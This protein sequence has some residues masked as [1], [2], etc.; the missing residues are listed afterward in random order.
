MVNVSFQI[1]DDSEHNRKEKCFDLLA[2]IQEA[3][4][5]KIAKLNQT[6]NGDDQFVQIC[7]EL[8]EYLDSHDE[9]I[10]DCYEGQF[11]YIYEYIKSFF[12][13]ELA[14]SINYINCI[15]KLTSEK[16]EEIKKDLEEEEEA[17]KT[18]EAGRQVLTDPVKES[19]TKPECDNSPCDTEHSGN[20]AMDDGNQ[21]NLGKDGEAS[22]PHIQGSPELSESLDN[23][24]SL[25]P[26]PPASEVDGVS[27]VSRQETTNNTVHAAGNHGVVETHSSSSVPLHGKINDGSDT[28]GD[29]HV[30][31]LAEGS[32]LHGYSPESKPTVLHAP[33]GGE[34]SSGPPSS[35]GASS[36]SGHSLSSGISAPVGKHPHGHLSLSEPSLTVGH[37]PYAEQQQSSLLESRALEQKSDQELKSSKEQYQE[38]IN[39]HGNSANNNSFNNNHSTLRETTLNGE[40]YFNAD[41]ELAKMPLDVE[42][43]D[44]STS[45]Q[46]QE[47]TSFKTYLTIILAS[48]GVMLLS[49]LLIKFTSVGG[50]FRRKK[51]EKRQKMREELD[52]IMYTPS[53]LEEDNIY[54]SY[55]QPEYSSYYAEYD[56]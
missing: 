8:G 4:D 14:K 39:Y 42:D 55:S 47:I 45:V 7:R 51:N 25:N 19:P 5:K 46:E 41:T 38:Q 43:G 40:N 27:D 49:V 22:A 56:N 52:R 6:K 36:D 11:T 2:D 3:L 10:K 9:G 34:V 13:H 1:T 24:V 20:K 33:P 50:Y 26:K 37:L 21:D 32:D 12:Q 31:G 23:L 53:N 17:R 35:H 18:A 44:L 15:D 48:L 30:Q 16:K 29:T 54:L 28:I